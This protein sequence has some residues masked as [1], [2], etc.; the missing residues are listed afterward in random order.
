M[1]F[2]ILAAHAS[3]AYSALACISIVLFGFQ[4][5]ISN[6]QTLPSDFF[7]NAAVGSVAAMAA[8]P[9]ASPMARPRAHS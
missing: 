8:A 4:M 9:A 3:S 6:V 7:S 5:W 1:P 2:G